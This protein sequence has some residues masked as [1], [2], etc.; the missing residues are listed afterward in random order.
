MISDVHVTGAEDP[1]QAALVAH[2]DGL[3][4]DAL[5]ILGDLFHSAWAFEGGLSPGLEATEGALRRLRARGIRIGFVP[6][7]HDFAL[8]GWFSRELG[9]EVRPAH[10][11]AFDGVRVLLAHGDEA[12]ASLGYAA[13]RL[14]LRG[15]PFDALIRG[16]GP[17]R[18]GRALA[19]L[20]GASRDRP[21]P[22]EA[23]LRA[24]AEWAER[25]LSEEGASFVVL[26][27]S[28]AFGETALPHGRLFNLGDWRDGPR[29]LEIDGG[30]PRLC[31]APAQASTRESVS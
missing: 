4:A 1:V 15:R 2:L 28:H 30:V 24:Q 11:Q 7:N 13:T 6:G 21:A 10:V 25:R 22:R 5:W 8:A 23:L 3:E 14:L 17:A 16:L 18:G 31:A 12:D 20:A 9:A 19:S 29:W 27:H 26:G